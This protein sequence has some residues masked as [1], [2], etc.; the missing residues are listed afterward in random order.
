MHTC[1]VEW[2]ELTVPDRL[3]MCRG[4]WYACP[5]HLRDDVFAALRLHGIGSDELR[6]AQRAATEEVERLLGP[7]RPPDPALFIDKQPPKASPEPEVE[8]AG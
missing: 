8:R 4:H 5:Q 6:Q 3:L 2:C 7:P 1:P